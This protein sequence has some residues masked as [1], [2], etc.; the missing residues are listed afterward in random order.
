MQRTSVYLLLLLSLF[1]CRKDDLPVMPPSNDPIFRITGDIAGSPI[2][3]IAGMEG[4]VL[5]SET[6]NLQGVPHLSVTLGNSS[7]SFHLMLASGDMD[8]PESLLF[9][10]STLEDWM[11]TGD[12]AEP[13]MVISKYNLSNSSHIQSI[14]WRVNGIAQDSE[15]VKINEPGIHELCASITFLDNKESEICQE[16][17]LGYKKNARNHLRFL[18]GQD[19]VIIAF[20]DNPDHTIH[21]IDWFI[22]DSL[23][24]TDKLNLILPVQ[25]NRYTLTGIVYNSNGVVRKKTVFID[26]I[27]T[28]NYIEDLTAFE[29]QYN[30]D[31]DYKARIQLKHLEKNYSSALTSGEISITHVENHS[32]LGQSIHYK[33]VHGEYSGKMQ[34]KEDNTFIHVN[35][36][37]VIAIPEK[38]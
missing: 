25:F 5:T 33:K 29:H 13:L 26:R 10:P 27:N 11:L 36:N 6:I 21:R 19:N 32:V 14:Q 12:P 18:K 22:N 28:M 24:P 1:S 23:I 37:L 17:I 4:A 2:E 9:D 31:W 15:V 3:F 8:M 20:F 30:H 34:C 35:L 38:F 16:V 7:N